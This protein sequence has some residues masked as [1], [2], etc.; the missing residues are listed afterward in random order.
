M[1]LAKKVLAV[2]LSALLVLPMAL[3]AMAE[4]PAIDEVLE[5]SK[6][7]LTHAVNREINYAA[8]VED[9]T[10]AFK[11]KVAAAKV[12]LEK[13]DATAEELDAALAAMTEAKKDL[14]YIDGV[15]GAFSMDKTMA[16]AQ[17]DGN[18]VLQMDW[19]EAD[20]AP[21]DLSKSDL[22]KVYATFTV[23]L[24]NDSETPDAD[25]FKTGNLVFRS[26][27]TD[28][29]ENNVSYSVAKHL[30]GLKSGENQIKVRLADFT[31]TTNKMDW[32]KFNRMR[33]FIDSTNSVAGK[34]T[35]EVSDIRIV[36][37]TPDDYQ[38]LE[39]VVATFRDETVYQNAGGD[40]KTLPAEWST[41]TPVDISGKN[42][43]NMFLVADFTLT[44]TT[45]L[46]DTDVFT[47]G[48]FRL[49]SADTAGM[50]L[51]AGENN[52]GASIKTMIDNGTIQQPVA[53]KNSV[54]IPLTAF[55]DEKGAMDW[56]T[57]NRFRVYFDN[58][59]TG[60][61]AGTVTLQMNA[62]NIVDENVELDEGV[63][64]VF[65]DDT[66]YNSAANL[67]ESPWIKSGME[68]DASKHFNNTYLH[69]N[70]TLT[71]GS[72]NSFKVG[73]LRLRSPNTEESKDETTNKEGENNVGY[74]IANLGK[75]LVAGENDLMIPLKSFDDAKGS[76]DWT[77][78][79]QFRM[80]INLPEGE[81][82]ASTLKFNTVE[83]I[84]NSVDVDPTV[85]GTFSQAAGRYDAANKTTLQ[86]A[87]VNA[88]EMFNLK[89][90]D[91]DE[92]YLHIKFNLTNDTA[93]ADAEAFKSGK[94]LLA[95]ANTDASIAESNKEG[96]NSVMVDIS[97]AKL[98]LE[99]GANELKI[100]LSTFETEKGSMDWENVSKFR[101]FIDSTNQL[102][103]ATS[104]TVEVVE[105]VD[106]SKG[107]ETPDPDPEPTYTLGDVDGENGITAADALMALQAATNKITLDETQL[108]AANVDG[109]VDEETQQPTVTANDALL[110]LQHATQKIDS[111]PA[112]DK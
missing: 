56:A 37:E 105:V 7:A 8:Y 40:D 88:D 73:Y 1:K 77:K 83:I 16:G 93:V 57:L 76:I 48:Y 10:A 42:L 36:D 25:A 28:G 33:L 27:D 46:P 17:I 52:V 59:P 95:S 108:L 79:D 87:W 96:E 100:P 84:D 14:E 6:A 102:V 2:G 80:Y 60:L 26:E 62:V 91:K 45:G 9:T 98:V 112:Q 90:T 111:F 71:G 12:V 13:A 86:T 69:V 78:V 72:E 5:A 51:P 64:G 65:Q 15:A 68:I 70:F 20:I 34:C 38:P 4:E 3:P 19:T 97:K 53:G 21:I 66:T 104:M 49:R 35:I 92:A 75:T 85:V 24:T 23:K 18:K 55:T 31:G 58:L 82:E 50:E 110:I 99:S 101:M 94:I 81:T 41:T 11:E 106:P 32:S 39:G 22:T 61:A 74:S 30:S 103:E 47:T 67:L 44:N 107:G 109:S 29:K 43:S 54:K 89:E 63:L